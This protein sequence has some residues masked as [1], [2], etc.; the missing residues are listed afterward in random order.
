[1]D[2][3]IHS[4]NFSTMAYTSNSSNKNCETECI[5]IHN[6]W[7]H[8]NSLAQAMARRTSYERQQIRETYKAMYGKDLVDRLQ[9][10]LLNNYHGNHEICNALSLWLLDQHE[11]DALMA[12]EAFENSETNYKALV[13]IYTGRKSSHLLLIKQ[14]YQ[15]KYR[16]QLEQDI[17][18][19]E[20]P[21]SYQ[22]ILIALATSHK[23]HQ[24]E[25]SP[26]VAKCDARRLYETGEGRGGAV[27]I[28]EGAILE[29]LSKR[30]IQQLKLTFETYKHI[31]GHNYAKSLKKERNGE[32]EVA[33]RVVIKCMYAPP[34]YYAEM[35]HSCIEGTTLDKTALA[36]IMV[37]RAEI[38]MDEIQ[39]VYKKKYAKDLRDAIRENNSTGIDCKD[40]LLL[41]QVFALRDFSL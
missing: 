8:L 28:E 21:H 35:L 19:S 1:M 33:L 39:R 11:R 23:S 32:F 36:R 4:V 24:S 6:Q 41:W 20:L 16:M 26:H 9:K 14:V 25:V 7:G 18:N 3:M 34:K 40:F 31:Y 27:G 2:Y 17:L 38:D 29:I 13:E 5:E 22:K 30:S 37:S 10:M 15:T 12:K